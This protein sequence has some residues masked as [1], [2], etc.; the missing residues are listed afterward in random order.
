[1]I[2]H[3]AGGQ[4]ILHGSGGQMILHGAGGKMILHGARGKMI[5]HGARGLMILHGAGGLMILHGAGGQMILHGA[6][7]K[8]NQAVGW[9][10]VVQLMLF[11]E[12]LSQPLQGINRQGRG[13]C[14]SDRAQESSQHHSPPLPLS[15]QS[16]RVQPGDRWHQ[17]PRSLTPRDTCMQTTAV[18]TTEGRVIDRFTKSRC[19]KGTHTNH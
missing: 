17:L 5:L 10:R 13:R 9:Q 8:E 14:V 18:D 2:L 19:E 4:M 7:A 6:R 12:G 1:M 15:L 11:P 16:V 3:G